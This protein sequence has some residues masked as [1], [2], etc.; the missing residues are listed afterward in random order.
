MNSIL[1]G[2]RDLKTVF[3]QVTETSSQPEFV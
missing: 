3:K 1:V 2:L